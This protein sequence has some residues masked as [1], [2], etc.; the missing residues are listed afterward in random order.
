[1]EE[2][3][4]CTLT[5]SEHEAFAED[6]GVSP[7]SEYGGCENCPWSDSWVEDES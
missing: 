5:D 3:I 4:N 2:S 1:M 7:C 6:Y